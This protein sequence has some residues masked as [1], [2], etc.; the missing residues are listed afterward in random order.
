MKKFLSVATFAALCCMGLMTTTTMTSCSDDDSTDSAPAI[1]EQINFSDLVAVAKPDGTIEISGNVT[2]NTKI[3]T[4][5]LQTPDGKTIVDL[6]KEG[7]QSKAKAIDEAGEKQKT[8][9]LAIPTTPVAVQKMVLVGKTRGDKK[10]SAEIGQDYSFVCGAG[11]KSSEGSYVSLVNKKNYKVADVKELTEKVI[12]LVCL[13][14]KTFQVP[15]AAK[16][17]Y[18]NAFGKSAV[19]DSNG[20]SVDAAASGTIITSTGCIATFSA[21]NAASGDYDVT[22]S[23][24]VI[25]SKVF[26]IDASGVS[27]HK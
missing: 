20:K 23:G 5:E 1:D 14:D 2:A 25:D 9:T 16:T 15:S 4:L 11:S 24:V 22:I 7:D 17:Q 27:L 13:D 21:T 19:F 6:K 8:F 18:A 3:K 26:K 12:D 10:A